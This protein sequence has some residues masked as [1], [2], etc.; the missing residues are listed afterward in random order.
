MYGLDIFISL[1]REGR[2]LIELLMLLFL[3]QTFPE[4]LLGVQC[5]H[6][7]RREKRKPEFS[8]LPTTAVPGCAPARGCF[9]HPEGPWK[10]SDATGGFFLY[11]VHLSFP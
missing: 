2:P 5:C 7:W 4:C 9:P 8:P 1:P 3:Q 6:G 11:Q 10:L